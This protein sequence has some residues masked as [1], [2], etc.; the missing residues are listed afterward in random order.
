MYIRPLKVACVDA[1][2]LSAPG[3]RQ[4]WDAGGKTQLTPQFVELMES[5]Q[6]SI[7]TWSW[8][9]GRGFYPDDDLVRSRE[10]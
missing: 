10:P 4:W 2:I 3:V 8:E 6:S 9:A 7:T 5:I 1:G